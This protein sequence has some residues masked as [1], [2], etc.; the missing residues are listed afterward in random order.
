MLS[1]KDY[2]RTFRGVTTRSV[3]KEFEEFSTLTWLVV[4]Y[5]KTITFIGK[6]YLLQNSG[7]LSEPPQIYGILLNKIEELRYE[8]NRQSDDPEFQVKIRE[9]YQRAGVFE[10]VPSEQDIFN[11]L[12]Y[13]S[14]EVSLVIEKYTKTKECEICMENRLDFLFVKCSVCVHDICGICY[15]NLKKKCPF[16]RTKL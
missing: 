5:E 7:R 12:E 10:I 16:C 15:P 8:Y 3:Q 13:W 4:R 1:L 2:S 6:I 14:T 11:L 9:S